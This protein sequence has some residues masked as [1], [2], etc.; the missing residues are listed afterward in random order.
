MYTPL[1]VEEPTSY[2]KAIDS[3]NHKEWMDTM[4]DKMDSNGKK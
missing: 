2:Q 1:E 3:S 4:R